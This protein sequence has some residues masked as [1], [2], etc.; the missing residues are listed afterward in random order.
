MDSD[1]APTTATDGLPPPTWTVLWDELGPSPTSTARAWAKEFAEYPWNEALKITVEEA[2]KAAGSVAAQKR[3]VGGFAD[4]PKAGH[5]LIVKEGKVQVLYGWRA[6]RPLDEDGKIY[7]GLVGDRITSPSGV[8]VLP[9]LVQ[10]DGAANEQYKHFGK[11]SAKAPTMADIQAAFEADDTKELVDPS[12]SD[13]MEPLSVWGVLPV[14]PKVASVFMH[15]PT[16]RDAMGLFARL[17]LVVPAHAQAG[18]NPVAEFLRVG[19]VK[20]GTKSKLEK[21]WLRVNLAANEDLDM[22]HA[23]ACGTYAPRLSEVSPPPESPRVDAAGAGVMSLLSAVGAGSREREPSK[24]AYTPTELGRLYRICGLSTAK[25]PVAPADMTVECLPEFWQ[26]FETARSK[27]HSAR[28]YVEGW[29]ETEWPSDQPRY[30][31]ILTTRFLKDLIALDFDGGDS[32]VNWANKE[33]GI[34]VFSVYPLPDGQDPGPRRRRAVAFEDT[35]DNH[36]PSDRQSM[37][38]M[39]NFEA[40]MPTTRTVM[41]DWALYLRTTL[42]LLFGSACPALADL[43]KYIEYL[44]EG[45]RFRN[46]SARDWRI[47]FSTAGSTAATSSTAGGFFSSSSS[48]VAAG[49][50]PDTTG[51]GAIALVGDTTS[52]AGSNSC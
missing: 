25:N 5:F 36:R 41:R 22:W 2:K 10:T 1:N 38:D 40:N 15:S 48:T 46:F 4:A 39:A 29:F 20:E 27:L 18:L 33:A 23:E 32:F 13:A 12:T 35:L 50:T 42:L 8:D 19:A 49:S 17:S 44:N 30:Q 51:S 26:G 34:S 9:R 28:A 43:E 37:L 11:V 21:E 3:R 45:T 16:L 47:V 24:R 31:R 6:C 7:T 14:H 52:P